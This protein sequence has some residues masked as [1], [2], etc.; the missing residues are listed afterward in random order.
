[1]K[2][3]CPYVGGIRTQ[4]SAPRRV[5]YQLSYRATQEVGVQVMRHKTKENLKTLCY[6]LPQH[7]EDVDLCELITCK[8]WLIWDFCTSI[9]PCAPITEPL[10]LWLLFLSVFMNVLIRSIL[11]S[12]PLAGWLLVG[13]LCM[14]VGCFEDHFTTQRAYGLLQ[15]M[16]S[17][18]KCPL[19]SS[20]Y[21]P[22]QLL[23]SQSNN[24]SSIKY[25]NTHHLPNTGGIQKLTQWSSGLSTSPSG[26]RNTYVPTFCSSISDEDFWLLEF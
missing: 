19:H 2:K 10:V 7:A 11:W 16:I 14:W 20:S 24:T 13:N 21:P 18:Q 4:H 23:A 17:V 1:M 8:W 12:M 3:S 15:S 5:L 26:L 25:S 6:T 9:L 22:L